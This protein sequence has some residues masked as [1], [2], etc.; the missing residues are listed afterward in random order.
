M[1]LTRIN[2]F[3]K[4]KSE[5]AGNN[6]SSIFSKIFERSNLLKT[7]AY[8]GALATTSVASYFLF[9]NFLPRPSQVFPPATPPFP[10]PPPL[11]P[12][13]VLSPPPTQSPSP[14]SPVLSPPVQLPPPSLLPPPPP[15]PPYPELCFNDCKINFR[16]PNGT[17]GIYDGNNDE[18]CSDGSKN[19]NSLFTCGLGNDCD[20]C[21][22]LVLQP[23]LPPSPPPMYSYWIFSNDDCTLV[24]ESQEEIN[25][26]TTQTQA[27]SYNCIRLQTNEN[28]TYAPNEECH[29]SIERSIKTKFLYYQVSFTDSVFINS[30][31]VESTNIYELNSGTPIFW[32]SGS[33]SVDE[34]RGFKWCVI[35][36]LT[37]RPTPPPPPLSPPSIPPSPPPPFPPPSPPLP[38]SPPNPP[39]DSTA[40]WKTISGE[41]CSISGTFCLNYK[42]NIPPSPP[43]PPPSSPLCSF[44]C[45][46]R[47]LDDITKLIQFSQVL[48]NLKAGNL[49][50][51][52][53]NQEKCA[54]TPEMASKNLASSPPPSLPPPPPYINTV[55]NCTFETLQ[56]MDFTKFFSEDNDLI[57]HINGLEINRTIH[58]IVEKDSLVTIS[59]NTSSA[60]LKLVACSEAVQKPSPPPY[61]PPSPYYPVDNSVIEQCKTYSC[62]IKKEITTCDTFLKNT[63]CSE[64]EGECKGCAN[65]GCCIPE[66]PPPSLPPLPNCASKCDLSEPICYDNDCD[67]GV[68]STNCQGNCI[69]NPNNELIKSNCSGTHISDG[70]SNGHCERTV[71]STPV[72]GTLLPIDFKNTYTI[73]DKNVQFGIYQNTSCLCV[74]P[75]EST[76]IE[77]TT[78]IGNF[79]N[80]TYGVPP[81]FPPPSPLLPPPSAPDFSS[82]SSGIYEVA[83]TSNCRYLSS[84]E[85]KPVSSLTD[86]LGFLKTD[87]VNFVSYVTGLCT[88]HS[89]CELQDTIGKIFTYKIDE[90]NISYYRPFVVEDFTGRYCEKDPSVAVECEIVFI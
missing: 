46:A 79:Y 83:K 5:K 9:D 87:I 19:T 37:I 15:L 16:Y 85:Y 62:F 25:G 39:P 49:L 40:Y 42:L 4:N 35:E 56:D 86:C 74:L 7:S 33:K 63:T 65:Y 53:A 29:I 58:N 18:I 1:S 84:S 75:L 13:L 72:Y 70:P 57:V 26:E 73:N 45:E 66:S 27:S 36:D 69:V 55:K 20:D 81:P 34:N 82:Y 3:Q 68:D 43:M 47:F 54:L 78:H 17:K 41:S 60:A 23:P 64:L 44:E 32:K 24:E 10:F 77:N 67:L 61:P 22:T 80:C 21:G 38:L 50:P 14:K 6:K 11:L 30:L 89:V 48:N 59:P 71:F 8:F 12:P 31:R 2:K 52:C 76:H 28:K 88:I 51:Q 90:K